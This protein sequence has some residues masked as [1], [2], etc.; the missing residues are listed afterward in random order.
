MIGSAVLQVVKNAKQTQ[1][2]KANKSGGYADDDNKPVEE[3]KRWSDYTVGHLAAPAS[4]TKPVYCRS[5]CGLYLMCF[6]GA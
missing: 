2:R 1:A 6:A 3:P 5:G 4:L